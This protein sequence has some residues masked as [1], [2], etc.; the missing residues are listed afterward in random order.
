MH[1]GRGGLRQAEVPFFF[2][3]VPTKGRR[4]KRGFLVVV[5]VVGGMKPLPQQI[6]RHCFEALVLGHGVNWT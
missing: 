2:T 4:K 3:H 5:V 6:S 1:E